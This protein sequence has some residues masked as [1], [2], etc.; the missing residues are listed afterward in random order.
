MVIPTDTLI[1]KI[2][3][4]VSQPIE[5]RNEDEIQLLLPWFRKSSTLFQILDT[6]RLTNVI[7]TAKLVT[8]KSDHIIVHQGDVG[9]CFFILL[10]GSVAVYAINP[11]TMPGSDDMIVEP[12]SLDITTAKGPKERVRFGQELCVLRSG[13]CFG[14]LSFIS[15]HGVRTATVIAEEP[16]VAVLIGKAVFS[17]YV[18]EEFAQ[19]IIKRTTFVAAHPLFK[20]WPLFYRN[21][22]SENLQIK[23]YRYNEVIIKQ[24]HASDAVYFILD[25]QAKL[26]MNPK[27][28]KEIYPNILHL[29]D[30]THE[31]EESSF[32]IYK[33]LTVL[34]KRQLR[35]TKGF[36]SLEQRH[37]EVNVCTVGVQGI[38][39]DIEAILDLPFNIASAVCMQHLI[40]YEIERS[41]FLR[42]IVKK[43][44]A[45]YR[46]IR[47]SVHEK[48]KYRNGMYSGGIPIYQALLVLFEKTKT[49]QNLLQSKAYRKNDSKPIK[50]GLLG[51]TIEE[52]KGPTQANKLDETKLIPVETNS[53]EET[54]ANK[55]HLFRN[56]ALFA[57]K[58]MN[59]HKKS[60]EKSKDEKKQYTVNEYKE[61]KKKMQTMAKASPK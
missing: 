2:E 7:R 57:G 32:D 42:L 33:S 36:H 6:A 24:G 22:L 34:E 53:K 9:N 12:I 19:E 35:K 21:L 17:E 5:E 13:R 29:L 23:E 61:L 25:G 1:R 54:H 52:D 10:R 14:E 8:Y 27:K 60:P 55:K 11:G 44:P 51:E 26:T 56:V 45:T 59:T 31:N 20:L 58:I 50:E 16:C 43:N 39:G 41:S 49:R 40:L 37:R 3:H 48:L 18:P 15:K 30:G 28:H 4:L 46:K 47:L 38:I